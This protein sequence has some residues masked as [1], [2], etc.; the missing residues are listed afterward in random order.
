MNIASVMGMLS[1]AIKFSKQ[2]GVFKPAL[3]KGEQAGKYGT[4]QEQEGRA[5]TS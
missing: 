1:M 2:I 4:V 5:E 3:A